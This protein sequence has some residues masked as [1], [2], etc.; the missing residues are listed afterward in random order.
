MA[1]VKPPLS[2]ASQSVRMKLT[3][4]CT[5]LVC[6]AQLILRSEKEKEEGRQYLCIGC[7]PGAAQAIYSSLLNKSQ[8]PPLPRWIIPVLQGRT[9]RL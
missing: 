6:V 4:W 2:S 8:H 3:R 9:L 1:L 5:A 7:E